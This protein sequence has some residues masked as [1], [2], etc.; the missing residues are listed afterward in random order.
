MVKVTVTFI[1]D[2]LTSKAIG[3]IF[4][5]LPFIFLRTVNQV[6]ISL[7]LMSGQDFVNTGGADRHTDRQTDGRTDRQFLH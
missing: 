6:E 5:S 1:I 4:E 7:K 2:L 3:F